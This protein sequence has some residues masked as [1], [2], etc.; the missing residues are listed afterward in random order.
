MSFEEADGALAEGLD[1]LDD[2]VNYA[3]WI[4]AMVEPHL[5]ARVLEVGAGHGTLTNLLCDGRVVV[6]S[7]VSRRCVKALEERFAGTCGVEVVEADISAAPALGLFDSVV[8]VNVLEHVLDDVTALHRLREAL[9][10]Q[11][12]LVLFVP[13]FP[14]LYSEFDR[15][16]GHHRRYRLPT[17]RSSVESAGLS[18]VDIRYVNSVGAL[19]WWAL[20]KQLGM[21]PS[22]RWSALTYDRA[23]VPVLRR[24]EERFRPP[25]GQSILCV[26]ERVPA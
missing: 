18:V 25:F 21:T 26:A 6:A 12:R 24:L 2:A 22:K 4:H 19:A 13:A 9:R 8:A 17:L 10:P 16:I 3:R 1:N 7:D 20:A 23:V 14:A 5:G 11:G 15:R